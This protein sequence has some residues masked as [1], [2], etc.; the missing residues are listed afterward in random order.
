MR[1][2]GFG[3]PVSNCFQPAHCSGAFSLWSA[4]LQRLQP[5]C[6]RAQSGCEQSPKARQ[7]DGCFALDA[8][9]RG[10]HVSVRNGLVAQS[11]RPVRD[12]GE[13]G[14][15]QPALPGNDGFR[16]GAHAHGVGAQL[17]EHPNFSRCLVR[18]PGNRQVNS[19]MK[20]NAGLARRL[21]EQAWPDGGHRPGTDQRNRS[22]PPSSGRATD[23][24]P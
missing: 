13:G 7:Q 15:P 23:L 17:G 5:A 4:G 1:T 9:T 16:H 22:A 18:G 12:A 11:R 24:H 19:E 3:A 10:Q 6:G 2:P 20:P 8:L 21:V 14:D